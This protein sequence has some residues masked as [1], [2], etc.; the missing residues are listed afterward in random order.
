MSKR[1]TVRKEDIDPKIYLK[2]LG[3]RLKQI[4]IKSGY[5]SYEYFAFE[6]KFSRTQYGNYEAGGNIQFDT[7]IKII[8][9]HNM[10][11]QEFF[12]EGFD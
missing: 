10:T 11:L 9:L 6:H 7:L 4:R 12:S 2:Q 8:K 1:K 5:T 3:D